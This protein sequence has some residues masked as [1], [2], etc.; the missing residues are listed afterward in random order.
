MALLFALLLFGL[1]ALAA[2]ADL[3]MTRKPTGPGQYRS[4]DVVQ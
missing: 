2:I 1:P 4:G 3:A